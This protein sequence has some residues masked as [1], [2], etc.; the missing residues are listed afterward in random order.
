MNIFGPCSSQCLC[1]CFGKIASISTWI[2]A[3]ICLDVK[4]LVPSHLYPLGCNIVINVLLL[5]KTFE[6]ANN[7][8]LSIFSKATWS[9]WNYFILALLHLLALVFVFYVNLSCCVVFQGCNTTWS[10]LTIVEAAI[11][12]GPCSNSTLKSG[13]IADY[14]LLTQKKAIT[15]TCWDKSTDMWNRHI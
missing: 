2:L 3:S 14:I 15:V 10:Y 1:L 8:I 12:Y 4:Y 13:I 7:F 11:Q 5:L 9:I 6:E